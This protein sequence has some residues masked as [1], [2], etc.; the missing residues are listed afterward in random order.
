MIL[1]DNIKNEEIKKDLKYL[2]LLSKQY[3][4]INEASTE[5]INL[6]AILNLPKGTEHFLSDVHGEYE[7]FIHVLKNAS[8]VIR[9]KIDDIFGNRLMQSEKRSLATLI[10]YPEQKLDMILKQEKNIEDWYKITLYRLVEVCRNVSSK[11]T[12]SKVRKALPKEFAYIIEE[13]LHEEPHGVDKQ[14]YYEEIIKTIISI[15]RSKEFI[16]A[17]SKLIQRLVI[18]RLHII[19]D[20][21]D[22]GPRADIIMDKLEEYHAVDIQWGNHDMLWMGAASGSSVCMANVIRISA[23]YANLSTIE[24][25]Y[26]INLLPLATF[27][28]EYYENDN[29][30]RFSPK[31]ESDKNYTV[32]EIELIGKMHKAIAIIQFKLE[33]EIIKR[34]PEFKMAHRMLLDD[35]DFDKETINLYGKE[36]KLNDAYFPTIDK[37]N[38]YKLT[39]AEKEL[40]EKLVSSFVNSE[41][42]NRHV[43]FLFSHGSLYLEFNSNLLYHGCI[44]LNEDGS[45]KEVTIQ[46]KKYKGKELLDKLDMLAREGFFY[47]EN[48]KANKYAEDMIWYLWTGPFSPL[49]GKEKMTT[50]ERYFIND[51]STHIEKKDPYYHY[52]DDEKI[53]IDILKEFGLDPET[54]HIINGHVPV[55]SKNGENPIKANGKLIVIDGGFSKAY[56]KKT[57]IAGYT[58][59]YNSFGLQLV[60]HELF[61]ST[62]KSIKDET[63]ILSSTVIF[64]KVAKRKS[65]GDTDIGTELKKELHELNLLLLAYKRGIIKEFVKK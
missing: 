41:K 33:G 57:G 56:H 16:T 30:K 62:E 36:Y 5:I 65:V 63:D 10:Y 61:E 27:A 23:R 24:D 31:I 34:H 39:D 64:E 49:F 59:I 22:R 13:L 32:K 60:S 28:M 2:T 29:C 46:D 58:L 3:P 44:P 38:P 47:D 42:L 8:G 26:G 9:R 50:F 52:R 55:E 54:S 7:Q 1:E 40:V 48:V 35:I 21:F 20:I 4:T 19:G 53:C 6:Q 11:Y 37:N 12:R 25:G 15:D 18:D 45:F 51:K 17:I 14:A 43:R